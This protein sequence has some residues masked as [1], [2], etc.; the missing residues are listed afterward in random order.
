MSL[1]SQI[2]RWGL[3]NSDMVS[4]TNT[5]CSNFTTIDLRNA[6][7]T[8]I[9]SFYYGASDSRNFF[10]LIYPFWISM[11]CVSLFGLITNLS[12]VVTVAKTPSFHSTT[13]ILLTCLACSDCVILIT[14]ININ[15]Q[16]I[17]NYIATNAS[18]E[19][20]AGLTTLCFLLSTGFVI[21][22]SAER[23]LAI[24]H[25]LKHHKLKGANRPQKLIAIVC[26]ISAAVFGTFIPNH[27]PYS[28][29]P[30][31][32]I[33]PVEDKF[34]GFPDQIPI[35][36][37]EKWHAVYNQ[38]FIVYC[39]LL[40]LITLASVSYMYVKILATL[41]KRKRSTNLQM[42][43][44]FKK[45]IEQVSVMV[46]VNGGVYFLLMSIITTYLILLSLSFIDLTQPIAYAIYIGSFTVNASINPLLYFLTNERYRCVVK[47]W[48]FRACFRRAES[49]QNTTLDLSN[50]M[51]RRL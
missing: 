29:I 26:L 24:C 49:P 9:N 17:F 1:D 14:Q 22:A 46:I 40:F 34:H 35:P 45:H 23:F 20:F 19:V 3:N 47:N 10:N 2:G 31:C 44:E 28:E 15:S 48:M 21:L 39:G 37:L 42:S 18:A 32:I 30:L 5:S 4:S 50:S 7:S 36:N 41:G 38:V 11:F 8:V 25:P 13:Y 33:W 43:A 12:F 16:I 6:S 51:E 27:L